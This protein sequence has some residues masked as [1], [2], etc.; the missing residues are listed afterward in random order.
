MKRFSRRELGRATLGVGALA[1]T[2]LAAPAVRAQRRGGAL[3]I[4]TEAQPPTMDMHTST[5]IATRNVAMH[6]FEQI[7]TRG[8]NNEVIPEL[9]ESWTIS[10]DGLTYTFTLRDGISFHNGKRM[11]SADVLAS[12]QRYQ[13]VGLSRSILGLVDSMS[14]PNART[15][16]IVLKQRAPVFLDEISQFGVP[17]VIHPAEEADKPVN[18][19]EPIGTGPF[20]FVEWVPDSHVRLARYDGYVADTRSP[21]TN[22]FGGRKTALVDTVDFRL[23]REAGARVAGLETGQFHIAE[24]IAPRAAE[25]LRGNQ[26]IVVHPLRH[27]WQQA[28]WVNH[29][30]AP[31]N[32]VLVR[33]AIQVALDMEEIMTVA[34]DGQFDLNPSFQ[35]PGNP[36]YVLDG[37][38]HFNPHDPARARRL[39][40]EAGYRN[41]QLVILSNSTFQSMYNAAVSVTEQLRAVGLNVRMDIFDWPTAIANQRNRDAWNL[42]FTGQGTGPA[43]GPL[44]AY[45]N[46]VSPQNQAFE[47]DPVL[48]G[49][50]NE[51]RTLPTEDERKA[52]FGR[53][54]RRAYEHVHLIKFGDLTK[55]Q[56]ARANVRGFRAYRI[57]RAWNVSIE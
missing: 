32:N 22:G 47:P 15:F 46:L 17:V 40:Q 20:R 29:V 35:Y 48:D 50:Y 19:L 52:A 38:E 8:E 33:R 6:V 37:R 10:P 21:G 13:R 28:A 39:L 26:N 4:A 53:F 16:V 45:V 54:Q 51:M 7:V 3:I 18:R 1:A 9:A 36:Y 57:P 31:T 11:T 49:F 55:V 25:R 41:E 23:V 30:R 42:W 12:F 27:F 2:G 34:A 5:T 56:A 24:D 44:A 43:V 14:A